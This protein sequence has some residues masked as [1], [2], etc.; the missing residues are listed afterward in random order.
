MPVKLYVGN[1]PYTTGED[2]LRELFAQAG[3][4]VSVAVIR[5]RDSGRSKG[6]GFVEMASDEDAQAAISKFNSFK[7]GD[8]A[9]TVNA[10]R[11]REERGDFG[12]GGSRGGYGGGGSR[13]G[14]NRDRRGSGGSRRY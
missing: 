14:G 12:G 1:L 3:N 10:A 13:G 5:D 2:E 6:F 11:P 8:R 4:V 9:L 7:L